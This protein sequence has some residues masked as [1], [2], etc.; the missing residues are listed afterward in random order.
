MSGI[1]YGLLW[2]V[3]NL[4]GR[5]LFR[6]RA[7]GWRLIP[8]RG[9]L[10]VAAN[11][12]SYLDIPLL[13]CGIPRRVAFMGRQDL[14]PIPGL[15]WAF[16]WLGWIPMRQD[17]LDR[18]GFSKAIHL[19]KEGKT[20]VIFPE[21]ART[22]DGK[23]HPGKPGIGVIVAETGCRVVPA[24]IAGTH[25]ALP[26]GAKWIKRHPVTVT[27]GTPIDFT[28]DTER[29]AG[30]ELYRHVSRTVVARIAEL[31]QVAPPKDHAGARL[32]PAARPAQRPAAR[33]YNAE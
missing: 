4:L 29:Y 20:V 10:L 11:H 24:Y 26:L 31:G 2:L 25:E 21:G 22:L 32:E 12:A 17:R 23:L 9:G 1:V 14:F 8:T 16:R 5:L 30:K 19:I 27:Y 6:Y 28:A 13:G 3:F 15:R 7:I 18:I 33:P